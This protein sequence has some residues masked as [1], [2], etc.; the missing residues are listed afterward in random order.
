MTQKSNYCYVRATFKFGL[1]SISQF[2]ESQYPTP[3]ING[4]KVAKPTV[5]KA[6]LKP[7]TPIQYSAERRIQ[8]L[9]TPTQPRNG[10]WSPIKIQHLPRSPK[11]YE[12]TFISKHACLK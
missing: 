5:A 10:R 6:K 7:K 4:L 12:V 8:D 9:K 11:L 1:K 2:S 3:I